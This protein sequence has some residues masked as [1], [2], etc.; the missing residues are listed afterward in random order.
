[1][2]ED[3]RPKHRAAKLVC[4]CFFFLHAFL[5][6]S[7]ATYRKTQ[8]TGKK[9]PPPTRETKTNTMDPL[10][11]VTLLNN[12]GAHMLDVHNTVGAFHAFQE[13]IHILKASGSAS[14]TCTTIATMNTTTDSSGRTIHHPKQNMNGLQQP[15]SPYHPSI[16][17]MDDATATTAADNATPMYTIPSPG[18][19]GDG[20]SHHNHN[21]P[22]YQT[23]KKKKKKT[24]KSNVYNCNDYER[25][26]KY[27]IHQRALT[28]PS[29]GALQQHHHQHSTVPT[30]DMEISIRTASIVILFNLCISCHLLG[31]RNGQTSLVLQALRVYEL[32]VQMILHQLTESHTDTPRGTFVRLVLCLTLNNMVSI[33]YDDFSDYDSGQICIEYVQKLLM[34]HSTTMDTIAFEYMTPHEWND[35]KLNALMMMQ[36]PSAAHAA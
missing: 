26:C 8:Q 28:L 1:M 32:I 2:T 25:K 7:S 13:A 6:V 36:S 12:M 27:Y 20:G 24:K 14:T 30:A 18:D 35:I 34:Y 5:D 15:S 17:I 3:R 23:Y 9:P 22:Y 16:V 33:H 4:A 29:I 19:D 10:Q 31:E 11:R 21:L